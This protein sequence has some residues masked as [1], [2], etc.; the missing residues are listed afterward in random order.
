MFSKDS[1]EYEHCGF[2]VNFQEDLKKMADL[3]EGD[4]KEEYQILGYPS[5]QIIKLEPNT[6][7]TM[8]LISYALLI[9]FSNLRIFIKKATKTALLRTA[10]ITV[11]LLYLMICNLLTLTMDYKRSAA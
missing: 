3:P 4:Q 6:Q 1:K 11:L 9:Y 5:S 2:N 10:I 7:A 8:E